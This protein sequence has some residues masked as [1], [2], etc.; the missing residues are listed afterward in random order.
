MPKRNIE[1]TKSG[2]FFFREK[3]SEI[4]GRDKDKLKIEQIASIVEKQ[5]GLAKL[6]PSYLHLILAGERPAPPKLIEALVK[7][8]YQM[9][10]EAEAIAETDRL[11][12]LA[13]HAPA[14]FRY[15]QEPDIDGYRI[16]TKGRKREIKK[17]D[18]SD[19]TNDN[20]NENVKLLSRRR[21]VFKLIVEGVG[22]PEWHIFDGSVIL[23]DVIENEME[24]EDED[25]GIIYSESKGALFVRFEKREGLL[26]AKNPQGKPIKIHENDRLVG[27]IALVYQPQITSK[28]TSKVTA[29]ASPEIIIGI[30][31]FQ[32][33]IL[34]QVGEEFGWYEEEGINVKCV[35]TAWHDWG[36]FFELG[37]RSGKTTV[38]FSNI[39]SFLSNFQ[40]WSANG[41]ELVFF[42]GVNLFNE[43]FALLSRSNELLSYEKLSSTGISADEV[44]LEVLKQLEGESILT[45]GDSDWAAQMYSLA[46][47]LGVGFGII[48]SIG[49]RLDILSSRSKKAPQIILKDVGRR[50]GVLMNHE[51]IHASPSKFFIGSLPQ[52]I[53]L[54]EKGWTTLLKPENIPGPYPVNGFITTKNALQNQRIKESLLKF[55]RVWF[56]IART[57]NKEKD[58]ENPSTTAKIA[59]KVFREQAR[60][61]KTQK[62]TT[63][64]DKEIVRAWSKEKFADTPLAVEEII[65]SSWEADWDRAAEYL[66]K[67]H[68]EFPRVSKEHCCIR[69]INNDYIRQYGAGKFKRFDFKGGERDQ[70]QDSSS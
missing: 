30:A 69:Q 41:T 33:A 40:D 38:L 70:G 16:V 7:G 2:S 49:D 31:P 23:L 56:R 44:V 55:L 10:P 3:A 50:T 46:K 22:V 8:F 47:T 12:I 43:G 65:L 34:P 32:D 36:E 6:S 13:G 62:P 42:Y 59:A 52:R 27:R 51:A 25:V 18:N 9:R 58:P 64:N 11:L 24:I 60:L 63:L 21:E 39:F 53:K 45:I 57:V 48:P 28:V 66:T 61:F 15:I 4:S 68:P 17:F 29:S 26:S 37:A 1:D 35:P 54:E 5:L 20:F 14:T 67:L 19:S